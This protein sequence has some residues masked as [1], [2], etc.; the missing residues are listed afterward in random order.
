MKIEI[1]KLLINP[2]FNV[3]IFALAWALQLF[4]TK[5]AYKHG[6]KPVTFLIETAIFSFILAITFVLPYKFKELKRLDLKLFIFISFANLIHFGLGAIFSNIGIDKTS[7]INSGFLVKFATVATTL[8]AWVILKEKMTVKKTLIVG[9]AFFGSYLITTQGKSFVPH[10]G[11]L[12]IIIACICWAL[13]N[14]LRRVILKSKPVSGESITFLTYL[15]GIPFILLVIL[16][17]PIFPE[18]VATIFKLDLSNH[19]YYIYILLS[20]LFSFI[21]TIFLNRTLKYASASYMT[22]MSMMTP[23]FLLILALLFLDERI[24]LI[25]AI[26]GTFIIFSGIFTHY[27]KI[28]KD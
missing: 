16:I 17:S 24:I 26:G 14:V 6:A 20:G 13:G 2:F 11:D 22:M 27:L 4:F 9:L 5:V 3:F 10:I 21:L 7:A 28:D 15:T 23:V 18:N 12:L 25:Q 1:K 19:S 8:L